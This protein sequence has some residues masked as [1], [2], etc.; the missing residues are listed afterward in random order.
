MTIKHLVISG[1]GASLFQC[2]G[3][4]YCLETN[5]YFN[6]ENIESI[7][8]TSAGAIIGVCIALKFDWET[9]IDYII[10]R[11][12]KDVFPVKVQNIFDFYTK[13]GIYDKTNIDKCFKPLFDAKGISLDINL[14]DFYKLTKIE[15]HFFTFELN[16][17]TIEDVS[18]LTHPN[19]T[20]IMALQMTSALPILMT[21]VCIDNKCYIDGGIWCNYPIQF[22][23]NS[24]KSYEEIL[25]IKNSFLN[26]TNIINE[27]SNL[28]DFLIS[29][30]C[31]ILQTLV[32]NKEGNLKNFENEIVCSPIIFNFQ[33]LK[34]TVNR[35]DCRKELFENGVLCS[36]TFLDN[37]IQKLD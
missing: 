19:I 7:Y 12:W 25:G 11:P 10:K 1:G 28:L 21:P 27:D 5:H 30:L 17:Y 18:Y 3:V 14:E 8:G 32:E 35:V 37:R 22:C 2:L 24:G 15:L 6:F 33:F 23:V 16:Q 26:H 9:I 29:F 34:E 31:K 13:K 4:L 20:V 36:Q